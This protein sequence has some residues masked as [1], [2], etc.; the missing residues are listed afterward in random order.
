MNPGHTREHIHEVVL[1]QNIYC[2]GGDCNDESRSGAQAAN[3]ASTIDSA[4]GLVG[5]PI[6][7]NIYPADKSVAGHC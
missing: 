6:N 3:P 2:V 5:S 4:C 7:V 1:F